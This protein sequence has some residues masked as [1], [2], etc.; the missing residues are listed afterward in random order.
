MLLKCYLLVDEWF[1]FRCTLR[2]GG[3][4]KLQR[5]ADL[6]E[7]SVRP[8]LWRFLHPHPALP[9]STARC[10]ASTSDGGNGVLPVASGRRWLLE[11]HH[12]HRN[13]STCLINSTNKTLIIDLNENPVAGWWRRKQFRIH[14]SGWTF[15]RHCGS[16][17]R[18]NGLPVENIDD[19]IDVPVVEWNSR[20]YG[21]L[22]HTSKPL[23]ASWFYWFIRQLMLRS[24]Q[25]PSGF[26]KVVGMWL[27]APLGSI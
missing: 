27:I 3:C 10:G 23:V 17:G 12:K 21:P 13:G 19:V 14:Q 8:R 18:W 2:R 16:S 26:L 20:R 24:L 15:L 9:A 5:S 11:E 22:P 6:L 4:S 7:V 25:D 1:F